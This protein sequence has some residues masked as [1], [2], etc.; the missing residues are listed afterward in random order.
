MSESN[1]FADFIRRVRAGDRRA[2]E[3]LVRRYEPLMLDE[4][5]DGT[6]A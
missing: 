1:P 4:D 2:A 6:P 5:D 3:E